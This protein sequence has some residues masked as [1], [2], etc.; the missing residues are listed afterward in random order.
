MRSLLGGT[1][2]M[3]SATALSVLD[4]DRDRDPKAA[5]RAYADHADSVSVVH[6]AD[7]LRWITEQ[8]DDVPA[9]ELR[10]L[11]ELAI[12]Q[13]AGVGQRRA[14]HL[15]GLAHWYGGDAEEA[16]RLWQ[17]GVE[18]GRSVEDRLWLGC[19]ENLALAFSSRGRF[20]EGL[21]LLG[22]ALRATAKIR[23]PYSTAFARVRRANALLQL[24]EVDAAVTELQR[25]EMLLPEI[26]D[27]RNRQVVE[28]SALAVWARI[29]EYN[30]DW[31]AA[32]EVLLEQIERLDDLPPEKRA[33][34]IGAHSNRIRFEV[35]LF[36]ERV[37]ALVVELE[38][39]D[40]R[41]EVDEAWRP[42]HN[43]MVC[44][45]K[46]RRARIHGDPEEAARIGRQLIDL[47][48][49]R[50]RDDEL[51]QRARSLG[52]KLSE[53][54]CI[55][56]ARTAY[57]MAATAALRRIIQLE[58]ADR[59]LPELADPTADDLAVLNAHRH[60]LVARRSRLY[61]AI[62]A[63][64]KPGSPAFDLVIGDGDFLSVCAWCQRIRTAE[65]A[66]IPV[67]QFFPAASDIHATH[68]ICVDCRDKELVETT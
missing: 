49:Q 53:M 5:L 15:M 37:D 22:M 32:H 7:R 45:L 29:H 20:F 13:G 55:D 35:Q 14:L 6:D 10:P 11:L 33:V 46:L 18:L 1:V 47:Y 40:D 16:Q 12:E 25:A 57:D 65:G 28:T 42:V 2:S 50:L 43:T 39:L 30:E 27:T 51:I 8:I 4:R 36:P 58:G 60:E 68:G 67:A 44:E 48:R 66:W 24:D 54:G 26:S 61:E 52:R 17:R 64:W 21:V 41:L 34:L 62:V 31:T 3:T 38:A 9:V 59:E 19:L 56:E 23:E 63:L